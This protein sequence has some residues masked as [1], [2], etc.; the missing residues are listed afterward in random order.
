MSE[1]DNV[2]QG[3]VL[4]SDGG[5][6]VNCGGWGLHGYLYSATPPKKNLGTGDHILTAHGYVSKATYALE[7]PVTPI[8]YIDGYGAI[9][10]PTTNNVAELLA[11]INGLTHA[12][13]F[14]IADVQVFT[15][16]EYVRKGLEFWV[17][18]WRANGWLKKD[19]TEP[20]NVGLWK[21]LAELRDQLTGRGTKVKINWVKG[22]S[23]KIATMEDILGNLLADRQA[24]VGVMSAIRNKIVNNIETSAA[25]GY[26]KHN[27]ERHPLLNNRRMYFNTLSD[28]IKP[29]LY[30]LGD[31][32]K[33]DDLLGKRISDGAY[34]VVILENPDPILEEIRN[35]QSEIA[36]N[37]DSIIMVRLD[38]AYRQDTHQEITRYGAL[39]MEQVQPYRLDLFC[40]DREPLTRE[41]RPPKLAMRAVESVSELALKLEQYILQKTD[42]NIAFSGVPLITTDITDIIYEK[43]EKIVKKNTTEV[44]TK[45]KPEYN[46]GYAALQVNVNYQSG[47]SVKAVPVTLTLG[48]DLL[49]RNALKRLES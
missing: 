6:R 8:H 30:Y 26:W 20:A 48:I 7:D 23:D 40:L 13:K 32:G 2:T 29:G 31:H 36:G 3:M 16:S 12:L 15:D 46:V 45:L 11:T 18:G 25:E 35:Y 19:Q 41:L 28:F 10:P 44:S 42:S 39:A 21:E 33:D 49:D 34:S 37:I 5:Y 24:T 9:A 14:D 43:V 4:Y 27:V 38:H 47:E 1:E 17:D 22:H